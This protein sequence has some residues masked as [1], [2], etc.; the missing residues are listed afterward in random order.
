MAT[1]RN[2]FYSF[3]A[4]GHLAAWTAIAPAA[5]IEATATTAGRTSAAIPKPAT[6][7]GTV[8]FRSRAGWTNRLGQ[9][10]QVRRHHHHLA[11]GT[12]ADAL[13]A[14]FRFIAQRQ[15]NNAPLPAVHR[16]E[17]ERLMRFLHAFGGSLRAHA[18]FLNAQQ[19]MVIRIEAD[20]GVLFRGHSQSFHGE[21]FQG[22]KKL[23][24]I[25]QQEVHIGTTEANHQIRILKI[26]MKV[27]AFA[28]FE[29]QIE[30]SEPE[31][32]LQELFNAWTGLLKRVLRMCQCQ[33]PMRVISF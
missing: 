3:A 10:L 23:G 20:A 14:H 4:T 19:A 27:L 29:I 22:Q 11:N 31:G 25:A 16:A 8:V 12:L 33:L 24:F 2:L 32:I 28:H 9:N 13:T 26:G 17:V 15:V 21:L 18:Q 7:S 30:P 1:S 6:L 5:S